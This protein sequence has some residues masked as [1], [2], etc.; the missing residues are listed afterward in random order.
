MRLPRLYAIVD[1]Q[2]AERHGWEMP[3]LAEAYLAGGARLLQVRVTTAG[4]GRFLSW[5]DEI[6]VAARPYDAQ[7][8]VNDRPD[9]AV[10][11]GADGV[12]VGQQ[13]LRVE[14]VAPAT[15][16]VGHRRV[17]HTYTG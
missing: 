11:A 8:I 15:A 1:E 6:V 2:T 9:I 12:H 16:S 10:L 3:A 13:D 5:C 7:V 4:S 14:A 17:V